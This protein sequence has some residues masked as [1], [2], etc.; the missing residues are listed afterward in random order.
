MRVPCSSIFR[1][2]LFLLLA[3]RWERAMMVLCS[4]G[5][6]GVL[7]RVLLLKASEQRSVGESE[8]IAERMQGVVVSRTISACSL[9]RY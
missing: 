7:G 8:E 6:S 5:S 9:L 2:G 3:N 4:M 1:D